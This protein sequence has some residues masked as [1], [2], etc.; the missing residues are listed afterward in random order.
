M[1]TLVSKPRV[2]PDQPMDA[3]PLDLRVNVDVAVS[4]PTGALLLEHA[5]LDLDS[6]D[7]K[8]RVLA[9]GAFCTA[10]QGLDLRPSSAG[11]ALEG[12][13]PNAVPGAFVGARAGKGTGGRSGACARRGSRCGSWYRYGHEG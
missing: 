1:Q 3:L 13:A 9:R 2:P 8:I 4:A 10:R 6:L 12:R 7:C 5:G 11:A